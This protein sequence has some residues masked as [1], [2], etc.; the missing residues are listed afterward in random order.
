M[1]GAA[2]ASARV[3]LKSRWYWTWGL[4][5]LIAVGATVAA[6]L[7]HKVGQPLVFAVAV[8]AMMSVPYMAF[9][10]TSVRRDVTKWFDHQGAKGLLWLVIAAVLCYT[11][12][13][14]GTA[15]FNPLALLRVAAFAALPAL[16]AWS[17]G[18]DGGV[19]WQDWCAVACI[20]LPFNFALLDG[21]W[22][23]PEGQAGYIM[24]TPFAMNIALFTF[25]GYR[26]FP[27]VPFRFSLKLQ[28][29]PLIFAMLL[30]FMAIALPIG[31]GTGFLQLH[32]RLEWE[33]VVGQPLAI[34][35]FIAVP[36]EFLFRGLLQ[37]MLLQRLKR[38]AVAILIAS[39][40]FGISHWHNSGLPDFRYLGLA[41]IAGCFYG[42][43]SWRTGSLTAA[44]LLHSAVD[45][46]W[47]LF[48]HAG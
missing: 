16:F 23:W 27:A 8:L 30:G 18:R 29:L 22:E 36:E 21:I 39:L 7:G 31:L 42:Y 14:C 41:A 47:D 19:R 15:V 26:R 44:A 4:T 10:V 11:L 33:K 34:F 20:W 43:T 1:Q 28:H 2:M 17:A 40:L 25:I 48:F 5:A 13:A 3:R 37:G 38:P 9:A 6:V 46:L 12:Y 45:T 35:F 32:P 24:N